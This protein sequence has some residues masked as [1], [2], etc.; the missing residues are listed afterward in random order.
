MQLKYLKGKQLLLLV[1]RWR[2]YSRGMEMEMDGWMD[3][4]GGG[5]GVHTFSRCAAVSARGTLFTQTLPPLYLVAGLQALTEPS[6]P[7]DPGVWFPDRAG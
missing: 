6:G 5:G 3:G 7:A 4:G 2:R 1:W